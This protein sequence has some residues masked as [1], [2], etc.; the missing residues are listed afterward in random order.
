VGVADLVAAQRILTDGG[1]LVHQE[2]GLLVVM[3]TSDGAEITR[4]LAAHDLFV[5]ELTPV[6]ADLE[7]V[8]LELTAD[9][10]LETVGATR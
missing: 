2:S 7:S 3:G 5:N 6:R 9:E 1:L 4:C 10:G 8:F